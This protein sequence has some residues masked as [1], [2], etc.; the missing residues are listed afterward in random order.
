MKKNGRHLSDLHVEAYKNGVFAKLLLGIKEDPELSFEVRRN[1]E[2]MVYYHKDKILTTGFNKKGKPFVKLLD[3]KYYK[4][5][6]KPSADISNIANLKS[7]TL[8]RKY[9]KEAKWLVFRYKMGAEFAVQQNIALGNQT[10]ENRFLVVDMEW[11][12]AQSGI[13]ERIKKTRIDLVIVDTKK[14]SRGYNDIYLTEVKC[15]LDATDGPSGVEAH[16]KNTNIIIT[17]HEA[18]LALIEDVKSIISVKRAL[19][20]IK[21]NYKKLSFAPQPKMMLFFA[22]RG[23]VEEK[24]LTQQM[25]LAKETAANLGMEKPL[26]VMHNAL[27]TLKDEDNNPSRY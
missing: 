19:G 15:G 21:G 18:C 9:F 7:L 13:D 4:E 17:K 6:S 24:K 22:Y 2:A 23:E 12:F 16:V 27:I 5:S 1:D 20:L 14:N 11:Q 3:E 10:F 25:S 26:C 8:I